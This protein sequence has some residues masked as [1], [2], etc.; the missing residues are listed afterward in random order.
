MYQNERRNTD[1]ETNNCW[2]LL[3]VLLCLLVGRVFAEVGLADAG[4]A[5]AG[6]RT[7]PLLK[8]Y[9]SEHLLNTSFNAGILEFYVNNL[10]EKDINNILFSVFYIPKRHKPKFQQN[11]ILRSNIILH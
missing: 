4:L 11:I 3:V 8:S 2:G 7:F 1:N 5:T 10:T 9:I 6:L